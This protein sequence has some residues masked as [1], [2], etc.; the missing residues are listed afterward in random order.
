MNFGISASYHQIDRIHL[1]NKN[2]KVRQYEANSGPVQVT[3]SIPD[4]LV[5]HLEAQGRP[6]EKQIVL[7]LAL[8]Y[9]RQGLISLGKAVEVS[10]LRRPEFERLVAKDKI[11]RPW[12]LE[13][14]LIDLEWAN[15]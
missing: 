1:H 4:S 9:Y 8:F 12:C 7:D 2:R 14:L 11:E 15:Q 6:V 10:G 13:H 3:L 5:S